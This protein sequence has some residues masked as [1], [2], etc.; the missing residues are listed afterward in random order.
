MR[1]ILRDITIA[2]LSVAATSCA[3]DDE[4]K[5]VAPADDT[6]SVVNVTHITPYSAHIEGM[7]GS[8][9]D[10]SAVAGIHYSLQNTRFISSTGDEARASLI[11][12]GVYSLDLD[13]LYADTTYYFTTFVE[14][15]GTRYNSDTYKF[16][17]HRLTAKTAEVSDIYAYGA[18]LGLTLSEYIDPDRFRGSYGVYYST[19]PRVIR[20]SST[21]AKEPYAIKDLLP[22]HDYYCAAFVCQKTAGLRDVYWWGET[23]KFTTPELSVA[24]YEPTSVTT[25]S[26]KLQGSSNAPFSDTKEIGFLLFERNRDVTLDSADAKSDQQILKLPATSKSPSG[27]GDFSTDYR[28]LK[29]NKRYFC[30]AYA[31]VD[32]R[33]GKMTTTKPH[34]GEVKELRTATITL[35]EGG[36]ADFGLSVI[37]ATANYGAKASS[38]IGTMLTTEEA[39]GTDFND[40]W[41]LP[42]LK[43]AKELVDSCHW[44]W[45][46]YNG[47]NGAIITDATGLSIFMPANQ[48]VGSSYTYGVYM[49]GEAIDEKNRTPSF[50]FVQ[51]GGNDNECEKTTD[52]VISSEAIIGV[53]LVKDK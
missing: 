38:D 24:T 51:D 43:E 46:T 10:T 27:H 41:R 34:Y 8:K 18:Q 19:R 5:P 48:K 2:A 39:S 21:L 42:T 13:G 52:N 12:R 16:H 45:R 11:S 29:A 7:F 6:T 50:R 49:V 9:D 30:R 4:V 33:D 22:G 26:A 15:E 44:E 35:A 36:S 20:E 1:K 32:T 17:T 28:N 25:F 3:V 14:K 53:R 31:L 37:W 23:I 47:A 40:G